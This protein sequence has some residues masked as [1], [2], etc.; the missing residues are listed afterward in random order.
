MPT[1]RW[2]TTTS[3]RTGSSPSPTPSAVLAAYYAGTPL[4]ARILRRS[5]WTSWTP[6]AIRRRSVARDRGGVALRQRQ[7]THHRRRGRGPAH[8]LQ[9][10]PIGV[11][12]TSDLSATDI[13]EYEYTAGGSHGELCRHPGALHPILRRGHPQ[14]PG[15]LDSTAS[16][17]T[18]LTVNGHAQLR[19]RLS[20]RRASMTTGSSDV[21]SAC[22]YTDAGGDPFPRSCHVKSFWDTVDLTT[23]YKLTP[24]ARTS[25][26]TSSTSPT[27]AP[28]WT[29]PT[30]PAAG[31]NYN[32]TYDPV[33]HRRPLSSAPACDVQVLRPSRAPSTAGRP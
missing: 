29:P 19:Q 14:V 26:S 6:A 20:R 27:R 23:S 4:P 16:P 32:P 28:R 12:Y 21:E 13:F 18:R 17:T 7:R 5:P 25:I 10:C 11:K 1:S 15:Q 3:A 24:T 33:R 2:T 31:A 22:L 9:T 8:Q 30:T